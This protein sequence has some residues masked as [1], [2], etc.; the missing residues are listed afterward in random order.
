MLRGELAVDKLL[1]NMSM[2]ALR[3]GLLQSP[4]AQVEA[5]SYNAAMSPFAR[6]L[7]PFALAVTACAAVAQGGPPPPDFPA[8]FGAPRQ[9]MR[10][11]NP[12]ERGQW[13][14]ERR[15]RRDAWREMSPEERHQL[16]R[17]IRDAG[18]HYPRRPGRGG[19]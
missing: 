3:K 18:Q 1:P 9:E 11:M 16:R 15:Q 14:E 12:A 8:G 2:R 5:Q 17:D 19:P 6:L 7:L 4:A 13:R 10:D